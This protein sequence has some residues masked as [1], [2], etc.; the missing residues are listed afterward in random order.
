MIVY[1]KQFVNLATRQ[2]FISFLYFILL[3]LDRQIYVRFI[4]QQER[5]S[6]SV[7]IFRSYNRWGKTVLH[8]KD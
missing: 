6:F 7:S 1:K 3:Y 2:S 5:Q 4:F 8:T